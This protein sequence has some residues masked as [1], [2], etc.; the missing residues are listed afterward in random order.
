VLVVLLCTIVAVIVVVIIHHEVL[1]HLSDRHF[2]RAWPPRLI[3]PVGML[4]L[5]FTHV[6][7]VWVFALAYFIALSFSGS[8][9]IFGEFNNEILDYG[10]FSFITYTSLG[11]GDLIPKGSIRFIA[12]SE[13]LVGLVLIAWSASFT[14]VEMKQ[15]SE[16]SKQGL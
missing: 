8:G 2:R 6:V 10:Y 7:E 5:I 3:L 13:S 16:N 15:I 11:Y 12:G 14:Y 4:I 9:E 1:T